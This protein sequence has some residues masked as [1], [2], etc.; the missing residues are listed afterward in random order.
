[1][2]IEIQM[3]ILLHAMKLG[4]L[5]VILLSIRLNFAS[6]TIAVLFSDVHGS[7]KFR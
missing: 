1:M 6:K 2:P 7:M 3:L 5:F 4:F